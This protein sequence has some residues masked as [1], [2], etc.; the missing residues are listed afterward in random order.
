MSV[1][2]DAV[3]AA[4]L[5]VFGNVYPLYGDL[6]VSEHRLEN[7]CFAGTESIKL[8]EPE[9]DAAGGSIRICETKYA[10]KVLGKRNAGAAELEEFFDKN[11]VPAI[12]GSGA[13]VKEIKR[14]GT[15]YS[16]EQ[17]GYI[18]SAEVTL[19]SSEAFSGAGESVPVVLDGGPLAGVDSFEIIRSSLTSETPTL[20]SG[21]RSRFVGARP[22]R[23]VLKGRSRGGS[24]LYVLLS[25]HFGL[26][27][28]SLSVGGS[29]YENMVLT[30]LELKGSSDGGNELRAEFTEVN[31]D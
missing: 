16:K 10:V 8:F 1:Q 15:V 9:H 30:G 7:I 2:T 17:T 13:F 25:P 26:K 31:E 21:I 14:C 22:V 3:K 24:A 20:G 28:G 5:N 11:V 6:N 4:L 18:A 27:I 23:I 12:S 19:S 29:V